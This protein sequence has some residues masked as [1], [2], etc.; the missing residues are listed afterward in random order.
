MKRRVISIKRLKK[1]LDYNKDTGEFFWKE[2]RGNYK[3]KAGDKAGC[4]TQ[5]GYVLITIDGKLHKAHRLA[6][7][8]VHGYIPEYGID[9]INRN[10]SDN[11]IANL[12]EVSQ[13]C[14]ARN[15][16]LRVDNKTGITGVCWNRFD[17]KWKVQA[18]VN[19]KNKHIGQYAT[20]WEAA[21]MRWKA[22][23]ENGYPNCRKTSLALKYI[24]ENKPD[25]PVS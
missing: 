19:G 16:T 12:R 10:P 11:R 20:K 2:D 21:M 14:N 17:R 5:D 3:S 23:L 8:Y 18:V 13:S 15:A 22:E 24:S 7:L 6:W 1:L 9:H 25:S 4:T